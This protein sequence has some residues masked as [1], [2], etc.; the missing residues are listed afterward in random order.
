[1]HL[2][3]CFCPK[4]MSQINLSGTDHLRICFCVWWDL[5][6]PM[7]MHIWLKVRVLWVCASTCVSEMY[8]SECRRGYCSSFGLL[9]YTHTWTD[10]WETE[11]VFEQVFYVWAPEVGVL[12]SHIILLCFKRSGQNKHTLIHAFVTS[13]V[14]FVYSKRL[15]TESLSMLGR[16]W[17]VNFDLCNSSSICSIGMWY[18]PLFLKH[19]VVES[20]EIG[21]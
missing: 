7:C 20:K 2:I 10:L 6:K 1:M 8:V 14:S 5:P 15:R 18:F 12:G 16:V 3:W 21:L 13:A 11:V 4:C 9:W 19:Q 17:P